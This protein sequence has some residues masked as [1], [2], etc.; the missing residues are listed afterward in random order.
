[1]RSSY[2]GFAV[3]GTSKY[4]TVERGSGR[5]G[6]AA[7]GEHFGA[8]EIHFGGFESELSGEGI[9][10]LGGFPV[11]ILAIQFA[12]LEIDL[13]TGV[14]SKLLCDCGDADEE[15][16][17]GMGGVRQTEGEQSGENDK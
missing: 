2:D 3:V 7:V 9:I 8:A 10:R 14:C 1:M 17:V 4:H 12:A 6:F 11:A 16:A 5:A 15:F 13:W